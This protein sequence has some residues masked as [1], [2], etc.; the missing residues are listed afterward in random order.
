M[1][2]YL[3]KGINFMRILSF[4]VFIRMFEID[5]RS[6]SLKGTLH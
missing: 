2:D 4:V 1:N 3:F 6:V 5:I